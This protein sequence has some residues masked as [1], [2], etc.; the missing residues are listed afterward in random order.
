MIHETLYLKDYFPQLCE[1]D[2]NAYVEYY[3]PASNEATREKQYPCMIVCPG[4]GYSFTSDRE[5]EVV[6]LPFAAEGYRVFVIRY[7]VAPHY[8]PQPLRE[9][10]GLLE[11][12]YQRAEEWKIDTSKVA[13]MGFSAG[14][15]LAAQYS[16]RYDCPEVREMFPESKPVQASILSYAVLTA[17]PEYTHKG[18]IRNFVGGYDP[19]DITDKGCSCELTVTEKTPPTFL[20]HTAEDPAVPVECSLFYAQALS[21]CKIPFELHIYPFGPHGMST[22]DDLV[23]KHPLEENQKRCHAWL[24]DAKSWLRLMG[25]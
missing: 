3:I 9:I 24:G 15:H 16:N 5:A 20:W 2:C 17:K 12:I 6:G 8:F 11:V 14:G 10:A 1:N 21:A 13:I 7:S 4:G 18:T 23:Y 19:T 25:F 22:A